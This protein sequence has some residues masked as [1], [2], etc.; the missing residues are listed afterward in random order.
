MFTLFLGFLAFLGIVILAL[1]NGVLLVGIYYLFIKRVRLYLT[2]DK[3]LK[4]SHWTTGQ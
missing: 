3:E 2:L 4:N 1:L